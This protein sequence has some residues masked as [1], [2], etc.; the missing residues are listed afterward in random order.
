MTEPGFL[1]TPRP[2]RHLPSADKCV[3]VLSARA[4]EAPFV[5][6]LEWCFVFFLI[7]KFP[8]KICVSSVS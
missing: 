7:G 5:W 6:A 2:L 3:V 1:P 8:V 4:L